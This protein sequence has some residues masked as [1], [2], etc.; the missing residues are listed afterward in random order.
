M[1]KLNKA[2]GLDNPLQDVF[3]QPIV[4]SRAPATG[5]KNYPIGQVWVNKALD[6][7]YFLT[8][9]AAGVATWNLTSTGTSDVDTLTGDSGGAI[10][11]VAG[12]IN[13]LGGTNMTV[14]GAGS[15]LT[16]NMDA[17][18]SLATSVTSPLYTAGAGVDLDLTVPA[19]QD[20]VL[21]LGDAIGAQKIS[22][23][24]S[25]DVEVA[26]L[27]SD[28]TFTAINIDGIIGATT[29]AAS[30]FTTVLAT[31]SVSSPLYTAGAGVDLDLTVPAGQDAVLKLGDAIGVN[32]LQITDSA[33]VAVATLDSNGDL[34]LLNGDF[35][36]SRSAASLEVTNQ[37]T[38]SD[39]TAADSDAFFEVAV[40]GTS[41]GNPGIRF[42]ISGGQNYSMGIDNADSDKLVICADNDLGTDVLMKMDETTKD[43][44]ISQG[45][46]VLG[47]VATQLQMN[48]GAVTDFIGQSTL[49][50]GTVT[51]L[52][53]N[54]AAGDRVF[55]T[56]S[57][58]NGSTAL[59]V[60]DVSITAAT[61][62]VIDARNP[63]DATVQINDISIVD[64]FIVRQN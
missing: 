43:V 11:P 26:N 18:I 23:T 62:F 1:K 32:I 47:A 12:N 35:V 13:V 64:W 24:D 57:D 61:S 36:E 21:K 28:G 37:L 33:D 10:S 8:K 56:R 46:L 53:T 17:A 6:Q 44:E 42:Q 34:T 4:A 2:Y 38:N 3:P 27:D 60:F 25:A 29:P 20:A 31:T 15:T 16:A 63:T 40:G 19:G 50:A 22:F 55:V 5:D 7:V 41:S 30:T 48:G 52:N 39:N 58:V 49:T 9:V 45:N 54:I 51:V 59:G 14:A